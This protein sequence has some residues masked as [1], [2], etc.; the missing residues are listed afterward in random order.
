MKRE[1]TPIRTSLPFWPSSTIGFSQLRNAASPNS[2]R[3]RPRPRAHCALSCVSN[4]S[5]LISL[6]TSFASPCSGR[7][8]SRPGAVDCAIRRLSVLHP[9]Q[10]VRLPAG[11]T[12]AMS[13]LVVI[14]LEAGGDVV[15]TAISHLCH[16]HGRR[17]RAGPAAAEK[18][19]R[20]VAIGDRGG[21]LEKC[22]ALRQA[23]PLACRSTLPL[24][25]SAWPLCY[26]VRRFRRRPNDYSILT[27]FT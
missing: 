16:R 22:S 27:V 3:T 21:K 10:P 5:A 14:A 11:R 1:G 26:T 8:R 23:P 2:L 15:A 13:L 19:Q 17:S 9:R 24:S 4:P 25:V 7:S 12:A 20:R 18:Q 6:A